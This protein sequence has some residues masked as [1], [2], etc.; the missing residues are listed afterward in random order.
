M[1]VNIENTVKG[2]FIQVL[3]N[4]MVGGGGEGIDAW[5]KGFTKT[6]GGRVQFPE[7]SIM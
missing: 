6:K 3:C 5:A 1:V 2:P 4:A 7:K